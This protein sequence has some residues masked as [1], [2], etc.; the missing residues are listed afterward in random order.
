M[1]SFDFVTFFFFAVAVIVFMQLRGV[2]GKRTGHE[3]PRNERPEALHRDD[4]GEDQDDARADHD[5]DSNVV[6]LPQ[7]D[8]NRVDSKKYAAI[9]DYADEG[10]DLNQ[11]LRDIFDKDPQFTPKQFV[12]GSRM[13]YDMIVTSFADGNRKELKNLL[14]RD[15]Y[16]SYAA[17]INERESRGE[18]VKFN[19]VGVEKANIVQAEVQNRAA[20][21]TVRMVSQIISATFDKEGE[22]I[23]GDEE[24]IAEVIDVWTFSRD[25]KSR[26]PNWRLVA[27]E[28]D[29]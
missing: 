19:F 12:E 22:I 15:V 14:S 21:V 7:R 24:D 5:G 9:D 18:V 2:L 6:T 13:A 25:L 8:N 23:E 27:S 28:P 29:A 16:E 10:T 17:A 11:G 20:N 4:R 26:D 1:G 3:K